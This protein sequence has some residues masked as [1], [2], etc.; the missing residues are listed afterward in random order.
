MKPNNNKW[1]E[2]ASPNE[3]KR[4]QGA[5]LHSY[6]KLRVVP[7]VAHYHRLFK[8]EGLTADDIKSTDDLVKLPFTSKRDLGETRDFIV[9]P[10]EAVLKKQRSTWL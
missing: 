7:F 6:L 3:I 8:K 5:L 2:K 9:I 10:D 4:R 1:W